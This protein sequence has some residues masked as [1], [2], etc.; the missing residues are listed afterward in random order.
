MF[1]IYYFKIKLIFYKIIILFI[2]ITLVV[3]KTGNN[4]EK[5]YTMLWRFQ[6]LGIFT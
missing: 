2:A 6:H 4:N 1:V 5:N 3:Y